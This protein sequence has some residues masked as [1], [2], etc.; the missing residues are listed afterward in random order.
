MIFAVDAVERHPGPS[1][2]PKAAGGVA[3]D[4]SQLSPSLSTVLN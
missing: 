1:S 3:A 4:S 2:S